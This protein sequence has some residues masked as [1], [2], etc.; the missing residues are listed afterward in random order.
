MEQSYLYHKVGNIAP[1]K[2]HRKYSRSLNFCFHI[3]HKRGIFRHPTASNTSRFAVCF[4]Q[5]PFLKQTLKLFF[6]FL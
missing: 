4:E 6:S 3:V 1:V 5:K 2:S